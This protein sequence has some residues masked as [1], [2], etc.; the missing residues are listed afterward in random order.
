MAILIA[1]RNRRAPPIAWPV[2]P[3]HDEITAT[4]G[5]HAE[6]TGPRSP[7]IPR[8]A[9][10]YR[11]GGRLAAR[12]GPGQSARCPD[13]WRPLRALLARRADPALRANDRGED[14]ARYRARGEFCD[15]AAGE[16]SGQSA[17]LLSHG[18]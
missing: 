17:L 15:Q 11:F 4:E 12:F 10:G 16:R 5:N 1:G 7:A 3:P 13:L 6:Q 14:G 9:Y 8:R 18:Q 2:T